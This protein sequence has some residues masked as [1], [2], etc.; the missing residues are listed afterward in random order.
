MWVTTSLRQNRLIKTASDK[1]FNMVNVTI[2]WAGKTS[3][4]R[5]Y[6]EFD[7]SWQLHSKTFKGQGN[8][9]LT[10][11]SPFLQGIFADK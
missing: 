8:Q 1:T 9:D 10:E 11:I 7:N 6:P 2:V 4:G 5:F 3:S